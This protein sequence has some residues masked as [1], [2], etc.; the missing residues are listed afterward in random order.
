[1]C[2]CVCVCVCLP[3]SVCKMKI[4]DLFKKMMII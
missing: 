1:M 4:I 3:E 2:V